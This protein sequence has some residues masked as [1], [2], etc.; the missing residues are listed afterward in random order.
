[1]KFVLLFMC[2]LYCNTII[3]AD[4][5][6]A[7]YSALETAP[8]YNT[9]LDEDTDL[10]SLLNKEFPWYIKVGSLGGD[11]YSV[12][13]CCCCCRQEPL[14][15]KAAVGGAIKSLDQEQAIYNYFEQSLVYSDWIRHAPQIKKT[16]ATCFPD[17]KIIRYQTMEKVYPLSEVLYSLSSLSRARISLAIVYGVQIME[18]LKFLHKNKVVHRDINP[19]K[20]FVKEDLCGFI[21]YSSSFVCISARPFIADD[22]GECLVDFEY[23]SNPFCFDILRVACVL[24]EI[25]FV[26]KLFGENTYKSED[27]LKQNSNIRIFKEFIN[28]NEKS[29]GPTNTSNP[30][31]IWANR[32]KH[33]DNEELSQGERHKLADLKVI[34]KEIFSQTPNGTSIDWIT[35]QLISMKDQL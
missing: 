14:I 5:F 21:D 2:S 23:K 11:F 30:R 20:V 22:P 3:A 35:S 17:G 4:G 15:L 16:G 18:A 26:E 31:Y 9:F 32:F 1:M 7:E 12:S 33:T 6:S 28:S 8:S 24:W 13:N 27:I 29:I 10:S 19:S 34:F 25:A